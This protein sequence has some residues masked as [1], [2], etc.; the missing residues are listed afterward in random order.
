MAATATANLCTAT[1]F[2]G[3]CRCVC[4]KTHDHADG[5]CRCVRHASPGI[6]AA[7][8]RRVREAQDRKTAEAA[9]I[10]NAERHQREEAERPA[11]EAREKANRE[12]WLVHW[13]QKILAAIQSDEGNMKP[14]WPQLD[15]V[16]AELADWGNYSGFSQ[17]FKAGD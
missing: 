11:R 4:I 16:I 7:H 17:E 6:K 14:T 1:T 13:R 9:K 3:A 12:A 8:T 15:K 5:T 10:R 2:D